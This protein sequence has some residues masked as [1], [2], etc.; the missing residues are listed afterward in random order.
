MVDPIP[1]ALALTAIVI[2]ASITALMLL[3][4]I[5]LHRKYNTLDI[6]KI[7]RLQG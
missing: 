4:T 1:Q 3:L 5:K 7:R 6:S 2:G